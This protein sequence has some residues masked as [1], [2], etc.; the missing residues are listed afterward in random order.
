MV[1][2]LSSLRFFRWSLSSFVLYS[3]SSKFS[4]IFYW[5]WVNFSLNLWSSLNCKYIAS[6]SSNR[7]FLS[8][9]ISTL[10]VSFSSARIFSFKAYYRVSSNSSWTLSLSSRFSFSTNS[11]NSA[12]FAL[13]SLDIAFLYCLSCVITSSAAMIAYSAC[14]SRSIRWLISSSLSVGG[15]F[16]CNLNSFSFNTFKSLSSSSS[17]AFICSSVNGVLSGLSSCA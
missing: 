17:Y 15:Y 5:S 2:C 16:S 10:A 3:S 6:I 12:F 11:L 8:S 4:I 1:Y 7:L 9:M 13:S 14:S